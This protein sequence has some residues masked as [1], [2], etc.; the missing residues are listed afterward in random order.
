MNIRKQYKDELMAAMEDFQQAVVSF[1]GPWLDAADRFNAMAYAGE[2]F[3]PDNL[4]W[5]RGLMAELLDEAEVLHGELTRGADGYEEVLG[6]VMERMVDEAQEAA[7]IARE[8]AR[9]VAG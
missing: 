8:V 1:V 9:E 6:E 7:D 4:K 5:A 3:E 2:N